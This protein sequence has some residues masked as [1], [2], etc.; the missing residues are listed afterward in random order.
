[1]PSDFAFAC[2]L[3]HNCSETLIE[4]IFFIMHQLHICKIHFRFLSNSSHNLPLCNCNAPSDMAFL[5]YMLL[6]H[7]Y[8]K[9]LI[10]FPF[11]PFLGATTFHSNT[12][13]S[14]DVR[15]FVHTLLIDTLGVSD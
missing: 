11:L 6:C 12:P 5:I 9:K 10:S 2:A 7:I 15:S 3:R 14:S 8:C 4:R 1:L 13:S